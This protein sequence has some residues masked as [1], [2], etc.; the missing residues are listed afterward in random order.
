V[1]R[2]SVKRVL[3]QFFIELVQD[4]SQNIIATGV[5][6]TASLNDQGHITIM[7]G[8]NP[9]PGAVQSGTVTGPNILGG[10]SF[11]F[12]LQGIV[13]PGDVFT[14]PVASHGPT[15]GVGSTVTLQPSITLPADGSAGVSPV[16]A[17]YVGSFQTAGTF[18]SDGSL[19]TYAIQFDVNGVDNCEITGTVSA[20]VPESVGVVTAGFVVEPLPSGAP[21][22]TSAT[23]STGSLAAASSA[24]ATH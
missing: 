5:I 10:Q 16:P 18:V 22:A 24:V 9:A 21:A 3:E 13:N 2:G 12:L 15:N 11:G 23:S 14:E 17:G 1:I 7:S 19:G 8:N 4:V 20:P 6:F